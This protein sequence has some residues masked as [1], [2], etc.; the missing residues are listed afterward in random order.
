MMMT[1]LLFSQYYTAV[2][3]RETFGSASGVLEMACENLPSNWCKVCLAFA[4]GC[5]DCSPCDK[6]PSIADIY[7]RKKKNLVLAF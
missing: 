4:K 3:T 7:K 1:G 2:E 6:H 5:C